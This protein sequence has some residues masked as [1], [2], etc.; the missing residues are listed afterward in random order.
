MKKVCPPLA[1]AVV[2]CCWPPGLDVTTNRQCRIDLNKIGQPS[3]RHRSGVCWPNL[4][5]FTFISRLWL[6]CWLAGWPAR[7]REITLVSNERDV[8]RSA[9]LSALV[10]YIRSARCAGCGKGGGLRWPSSSS[11]SVALTGCFLLSPDDGDR[12]RCP[13]DYSAE[14]PGLP[15]LMYWLCSASSTA[16]A[17]TIV[18][19]PPPD[20]RPGPAHATISDDKFRSRL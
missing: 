9:F 2:V 7:D 11:S 5:V 15:E 16:T 13:G 17:T 4:S 3:L 6:A 14:H 12:C 1:V 20:G 8:H 19:F 10:S 18:A